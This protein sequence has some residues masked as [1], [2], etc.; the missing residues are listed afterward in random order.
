MTMQLIGADL[1]CR[2]KVGDWNFAG[3]RVRA[4]QTSAAKGWLQFEHGG[5]VHCTRFVH[6]PVAGGDHFTSNMINTVIGG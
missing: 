4:P 2:G 3:I 1:L 6:C 5:E